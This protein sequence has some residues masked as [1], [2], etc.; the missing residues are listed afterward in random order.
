ML[1]CLSKTLL[2]G[3]M[4]VIAGI[5]KLR[6]ALGEGTLLP[7]QQTSPEH[8]TRISLTLQTP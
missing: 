4:T 2:L 7:F 1:F 3:E 6:A 8:L 5:G